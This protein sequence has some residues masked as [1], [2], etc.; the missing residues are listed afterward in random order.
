MKHIFGLLLS[1]LLLVPANNASAQGLNGIR[2]ESNTPI[3][4][5]VDGV[6][7]C[8]MV[9]SCMVANLRRGTYL[10]EVFAA[11]SGGYGSPQIVFSENVRYSGVGIR[12]IFVGGGNSHGGNIYVP[13]MLRPMDDRTF[14]EFLARIKAAKFDSDKKDIIEMATRS[15]MFFTA[16]VKALCETYKFDSERLWLLKQMYPSIIDRERA[17][18]LTDLLSFSNSKEE[19]RKYTE[20]IDRR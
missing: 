12:D 4:V 3:E 7:V 6:K 15:N 18:L 10:I 9:N 19:F 5:F 2:V 20:S 17:F 11:P 13:G 8:N 1:L 16:Q 14:D